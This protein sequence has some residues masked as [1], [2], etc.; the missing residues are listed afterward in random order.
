MEILKVILL[1][2][3]IMSLVF[4]G[5]AVQTLIK[6]RGKFPNTHIGSN[7]YMKEN[8]ITCTTTFDNMEQAKAR[9]EYRFKKIEIE[10][11]DLKYF[12]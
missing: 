1:S 5:L 7:K 3:I 10:N 4:L 12:C 2:I 11:T 9:K 8:G 6:E